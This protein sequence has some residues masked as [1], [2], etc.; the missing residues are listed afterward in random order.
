V[1]FRRSAFAVL[2]GIWACLL[3]MSVSAEELVSA[4]ETV[5]VEGAVSMEHLFGV[6]Y[7]GVSLNDNGARAR[8][9]DELRSSPVA[10]LDFIGNVDHKHL[11]LEGEYKGS[12]DYR[13]AGHADLAGAAVF[14][15][16]SE[17][18]WHHLDAIPYASRPE[19]I[20]RLDPDGV[21]NSGDEIDDKTLV[22]IEDAD[23]DDE[24]G[25]RL[26]YDEA[27]AIFK[28]GEAPAHLRLKYWR[29][30]KK[31]KKQL[32]F[33]E[34]GFE[35]GSHTTP[36]SATTCNSC[37]L[38]A[39]TRDIKRITDEMTASVDAHIGYVDLSLEQLLRLLT[40]KEQIPADAYYG[41]S[42]FGPYPD[43]A[44][45]QHDADPESSL[46]Q[47]TAKARTSLSGGFVA[48]AAY[49]YGKR[50]NRSD[51]APATATPSGADGV[52]AEATIQKLAG[53]ITYMP[54]T[55][56]TLNL[57]YRLLDI[58]I[59]NA[60]FITTGDSR[61]TTGPPITYPVRDSVDLRRTELA[62][63]ATWRA[64]SKLTLKGEA[65]R[66]I[67]RRG[68]AGDTYTFNSF[69]SPVA[70]GGVIDPDW[71][72]PDKEYL[73]Q[74]RISLTARPLGRQALKLNS[75]YRYQHSSD[76]AY[77]SSFENRHEAFAGFN[78]SSKAYWGAS[79]ASRVQF[80]RNDKNG[81]IVS[82]ILDPDGAG[83]NPPIRT[84]LFLP[85]SRSRNQQSFDVGFWFTPLYTLTAGINYGYLRNKTTQDILFGSADMDM[86]TTAFYNIEGEADYLVRSHTLS[87]YA[88]LQLLEGLSL[89][90][91]A[92]YLQSA[93]QFTPQPFYQVVDAAVLPGMTD[94]LIISSAGLTEI[95]RTS[96]RQQGVSAGVD[97]E[98]STAWHLGLS[99]SV[100][101]YDDRYGDLLDGSAQTLMA[102][103]ARRW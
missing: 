5:P 65:Q 87:L 6:G 12:N 82:E 34:E 83:G 1:I 27:E 32:R 81:Q 98:P 92:Y 79:I 33:A 72:L 54:V 69:L 67:I 95:S 73:D 38:Q 94:N 59:D 10:N 61:A 64:T 70:S 23:P 96:I 58:D 4:E 74:L 17:R 77:G 48:D 39:Q 21:A 30:T 22:T 78:Y 15:I 35:T 13:A 62:A 11:Y 44:S 51:L 91:D 55:D 46:L 68:S 31:G 103:L 99:Y 36:P 24:L 93:A 86:A 18:F 9:Y 100:D 52:S 85:A 40:I 37:H 53:N 90:T 50:E 14:N 43:T 71:S 89:R 25:L 28:L 84:E 47:T 29:Q 97:W 101:I 76:P 63:A 60:D 57:R 2:L 80:D 19:G 8:E 16:S 88:V 102:T 20:T 7:N 45:F 49:T 3:P 26:Q 75:W 42:A 56:L 41:H 66:E